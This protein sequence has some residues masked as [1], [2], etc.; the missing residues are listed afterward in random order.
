M[1]TEKSAYPQLSITKIKSPNRA[2]AFPIFGGLAKIIILIPVF[3]EVAI[4]MFY[5]FVLQIFNSFYVLF[6]KEYWR[7]CFDITVGTLNLIAKT[8]FFFSGL[9]DKHPGFNLKLNGD[10]DL[11][12]TYPQTPRPFYAIPILGGLVRGVLII[13]F[14]IYTQVITNG[15]RIGTIGSSVL[16]LLNGKYPDS[17]YE[18]TTDAV[19]LS[20]SELAY[21]AG[22]SDKYPSFKINMNHQTIKIFL[23]IVGTILVFSQ[24]KMHRTETKPEDFRNKAPYMQNIPNRNYP[25]NYKNYR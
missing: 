5:V 10:F 7:Y 3:I 6:N 9:S 20:M 17:T 22:I 4:L 1:D 15:A 16:V 23:I 2:W 24:W 25:P 21:F 18:L 19:R 11:K 12:F 8:A 13:P 14:A